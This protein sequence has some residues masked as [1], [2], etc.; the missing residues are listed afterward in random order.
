MAMTDPA[1]RAS[2][3]QLTR[4]ATKP[5]REHAILAVALL[6]PCRSSWAFGKVGFAPPPLPSQL[7]VTI[8]VKVSE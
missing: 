2:S 3:R 7:V 6:S 5:D 1:I 4:G 8:I